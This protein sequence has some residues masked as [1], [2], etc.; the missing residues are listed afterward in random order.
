MLYEVSYNTLTNDKCFRDCF[1][2]EPIA[3]TDQENGKRYISCLRVVAGETEEKERPVAPFIAEEN[4]GIVLYA[5]FP[6]ARIR[7]INNAED[8]KVQSTFSNFF[9]FRAVVKGST[10]A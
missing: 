7:P 8:A 10:N 3:Y 6:G 5:M 9:Y 4:I 1:I 2:Y